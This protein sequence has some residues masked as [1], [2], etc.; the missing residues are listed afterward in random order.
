VGTIHLLVS[1]NSN[2]RNAWNCCWI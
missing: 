2:F 1:T